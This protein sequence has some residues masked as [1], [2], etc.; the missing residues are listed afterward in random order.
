MDGPVHAGVGE[1][2]GRQAARETR[3]ASMGRM[4]EGVPEPVEFGIVRRIGESRQE[5]GPDRP[6]G[7]EAGQARCCDCP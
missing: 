3:Q 2:G 1:G 4:V 6:C 5:R 7:R